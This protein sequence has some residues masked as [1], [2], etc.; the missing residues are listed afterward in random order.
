MPFSNE[1]DVLRLNAVFGKA[2]FGDPKEVVQL[3]L[4]PDWETFDEYEAA[5]QAGVKAAFKAASAMG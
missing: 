4:L 3:F 1:D 5:I 2:A